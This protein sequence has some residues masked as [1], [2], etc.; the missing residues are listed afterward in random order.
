MS[1]ESW[2][3]VRVLINP[4]SGLGLSLERVRRAVE[5]YWDVPGTDLTYQVSLNAADGKAKAKRA[6]AD[7]VDTLLVV[8][9]DG[10]VSSVGSVVI[11]SKLVLGVLP[12]GSGN[13]FARHFGIPLDLDGAAR[14]LASAKRRSIDVGA[15]NEH[16]FFITCSMA[17]DAALVRSFEK[18]PVRGIIPYIFA[19]MYQFF[20]YSPQPI[21]AELDSDE[22]LRFPDPLVFTVANLTQYGAGARIAPHACPDD[23]I[24]ELVVVLRQDVPDLVADIARFFDGTINQIPQVVSRRFR[25][26]TVRRKKPTPIQAD[27]ELVDMPTEMAVRV[28]QKALDVLVPVRHD[29]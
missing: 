6:I 9:G 18:S 5:K 14:A 15:V 16:P 20:E 29:R 2:R 22:Q 25:H 28:Y 10:M 13:G 4:K 19:G 3:R 7:G 8:G 1:S 23:G 21:E 12:A 11:G 26:L 27:G 17:W 24:L